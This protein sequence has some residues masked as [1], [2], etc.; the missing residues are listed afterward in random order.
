M[1]NYI[2]LVRAIRG[3]DR[4]RAFMLQCHGMAWQ[5]AADDQW[6]GLTESERAWLRSLSRLRAKA[7]IRCTSAEVDD[8]ID[9]CWSEVI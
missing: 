4:A 3:L 2:K 1:S 9:Q 6:Q 8:A 5:L 7:T